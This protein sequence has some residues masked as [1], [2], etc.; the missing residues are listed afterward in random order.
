MDLWLSSC[1]Q[2]FRAEGGFQG[3]RLILRFRYR[4][5]CL[6]ICLLWDYNTQILPSLRRVWLTV[7]G[8]RFCH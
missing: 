8:G 1:P 3:I 7:Q 2:V 5:E 4:F 6:G